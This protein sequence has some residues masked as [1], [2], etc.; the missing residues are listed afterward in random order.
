MSQCGVCE[1]S[2]SMC[3][4]PTTK[5]IQE[6]LCKCDSTLTSLSSSGAR[7]RVAGT[8]I[9]TTRGNTIGDGFVFGG[10]VGWSSSTVI[11]DNADEGLCASCVLE[12]RL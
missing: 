5:H 3:A 8:G 11:S 2:Q 10:P 9:F 6:P 7:C 4:F 12:Y 1:K